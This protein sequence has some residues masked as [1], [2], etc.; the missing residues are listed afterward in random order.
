MVRVVQKYRDFF[1]PMLDGTQSTAFS[2]V[3]NMMKALCEMEEVT[4]STPVE[5]DE[6]QRRMVDEITQRQKSSKDFID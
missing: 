4:F 6:K 3:A 5:S 2:K 1:E